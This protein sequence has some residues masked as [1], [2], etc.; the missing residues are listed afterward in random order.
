VRAGQP[1]ELRPGEQEFLVEVLRRG[2]HHS[3]RL[4]PLEPDLT[5]VALEPAAIWV[6][7]IRETVLD[8][9][10]VRDLRRQSS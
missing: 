5:L 9:R 6:W 7:P 10:R 8:D 1:S 3:V 2:D 4:A